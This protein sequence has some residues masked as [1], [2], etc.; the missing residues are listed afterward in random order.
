VILASGVL[1]ALAGG[2]AAD[3]G[4]RSGLRGG[5]L[6]G[7]V[8]AAGLA[9]PSAL[10]PMAP[11]VAI[12]GIALFVFLLAGTITGLVTATTMAVILPN[13]LRGLCVGA[14]IAFGGLIALGGGPTV[15]TMVS[16]LLGGEAHLAPALAIVG[17]VV[18]VAGFLGFFVAMR[19]VPEPIR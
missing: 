7:A 9:L 13:E 8:I 19:N 2:F 17:L 15:V 16:T 4:H 12:F 3:F 11:S 10:F 5:I 6:F 18:S 1:G 14:F